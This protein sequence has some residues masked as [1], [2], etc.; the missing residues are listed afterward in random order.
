ML[1]DRQN[2]RALGVTFFETE[3]EMRRGD[4]ALDAMSPQGGGRRMSVEMYE[5]AIDQ[6]L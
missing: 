1:I 5:V 3:E 2:G 6:Q 4:E